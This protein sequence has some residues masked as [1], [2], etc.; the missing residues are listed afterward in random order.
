MQAT[1]QI[2]VYGTSWCPDC[3][4]A[5]RVLDEQKATYRY[6]NIEEDEA[7]A[8]YVMQVNQGNRSVPTI[9][10]PDGSILVEPAN[11]ELKQKLV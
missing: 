4:R 1:S 5:L 11:A 8:E 3:R 10:F 9:V 7:A 6:V 2:T